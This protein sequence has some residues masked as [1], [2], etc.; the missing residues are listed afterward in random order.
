VIKGI[1]AAT[2]ANPPVVDMQAFQALMQQYQQE[3]MAAQAERGKG[4]VE[5]NKVWLAENGKK[6]GMTTTPSGLQY[7]VMASGTG[8]QPAETDT[9]SVNYKG[10]LPDGTVF[11]ESSRHGG[12]ATFPLHGVIKGWTEALKL[13][14]EGDKWRIFLPSDLAYG[15]SGSPPTIPPNQLLIFEVELLKVLPPQPGGPQGP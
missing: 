13:M 7:E 14:K 6:A 12:P 11:D 2:S 8:K 15:P 5:K 1:Q 3:V 10:Y 4:M 9:V